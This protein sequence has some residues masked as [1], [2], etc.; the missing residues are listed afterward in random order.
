MR[1]L[2]FLFTFIIP[3]KNLK[4]IIFL[5]ISFSILCSLS[6][7]SQT[8]YVWSH[9]SLAEKIYLQL[10]GKIYTTDKTIW[11]KAVVTNAVNHVPTQLSGVLYVELIGPDERLI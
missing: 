2:F 3:V 10:D 5:T 7:Q 6:S 4:Q 11:F 8:N 1:K 9:A